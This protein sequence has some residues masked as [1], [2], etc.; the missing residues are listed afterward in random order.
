MKASNKIIKAIVTSLV[1]ISAF[2]SPRWLIGRQF[3]ILELNNPS[4]WI[5]IAFLGISLVY[6]IMYFFLKNIE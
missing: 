3:K 2:L 1:G 4:T 5:G 6:L